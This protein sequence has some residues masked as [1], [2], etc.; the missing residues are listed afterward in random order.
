MSRIAFR[1]GVVAGGFLTGFVLYLLLAWAHAALVEL[2]WLLPSESPE[3]ATQLRACVLEG[4]C[5]EYPVDC[6]PGETCATMAELPEGTPTVWLHAATDDPESW[7]GPS[8]LREIEV[9]E[10]AIGLSLWL[11]SGLLLLLMVKPRR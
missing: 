3:K 8:N 9:P 1:W 11:L 4:A 6:A 2:R 7:S 5:S 10:P